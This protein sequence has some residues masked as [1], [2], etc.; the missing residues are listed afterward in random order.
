VVAYQVPWVTEQLMRRKAI[1]QHVSLPNLLLQ[2]SWVPELLQDRC[3]P[4][5]LARAL[6][7]W[8]DQPSRIQDYQSACRSLLLDLRQGAAARVAEVVAGLLRP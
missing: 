8:Q 6:Q 4:D 1:V 2:A 5:L 3:T 7:D